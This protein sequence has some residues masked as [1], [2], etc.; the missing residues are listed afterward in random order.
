MQGLLS[1]ENVV[2][3]EM[4]SGTTLSDDQRRALRGMNESTSSVLKVEAL[5]G[6]GET[7]LSGFLLEA[8]VPTITDTGGSVVILVPSRVLTDE[9]VESQDRM[10]SFAAKTDMGSQVLWLGCPAAGQGSNALWE[11]ELTMM[12]D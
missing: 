4:R 5:A 6:T 2:A 9:L 3:I 1:D 7:L 8:I 11:A 10:G 12:V